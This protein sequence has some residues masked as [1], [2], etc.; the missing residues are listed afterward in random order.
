MTEFKHGEMVCNAGELFYVRVTSEG[1]PDFPTSDL[2]SMPIPTRKINFP[3]T[4][5]RPR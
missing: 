5:G 2:Q 3:S 4:T 1:E